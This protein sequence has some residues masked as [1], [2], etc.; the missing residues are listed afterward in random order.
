VTHLERSPR[1]L[2][3]HIHGFVSAA[4]P[5]SAEGASPARPDRFP[6]VSLPSNALEETTPETLEH[7]AA[8]TEI[9]RALSAGNEPHCLTKDLTQ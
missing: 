8:L 1:D 7:F 5:S 4:A 9:C 6:L 2:F 3:E